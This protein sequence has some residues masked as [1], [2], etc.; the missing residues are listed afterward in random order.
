MSL[1]LRPLKAS[2]LLHVITGKKFK[3]TPGLNRLSEDAIQLKVIQ[4]FFN[5][6]T[7]GFSIFFALGYLR[8]RMFFRRITQMEIIIDI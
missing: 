7:R 1:E 8:A 6:S 4:T 5:K 2:T 3:V